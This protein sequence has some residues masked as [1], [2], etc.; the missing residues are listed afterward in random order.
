MPDTMYCQERELKRTDLF[1]IEVYNSIGEFLGESIIKKYLNNHTE[2]NNKVSEIIK[3]TVNHYNRHGCYF[4]SNDLF[5]DEGGLYYHPW[6]EVDGVSMH[7]KTYVTVGIQLRGETFINR[8]L[9]LFK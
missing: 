7:R 1:I 8:M 6:V 5:R 2:V 4:K 3:G 9:A